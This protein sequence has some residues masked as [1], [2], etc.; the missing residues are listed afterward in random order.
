MS[1]ATILRLSEKR[2]DRT[3]GKKE[4]P[5]DIGELEKSIFLIESDGHIVDRI[6]DSTRRSQFFAVVENS[7]ECVHQ[8]RFAVALAAKRDADGQTSDERGGNHRIFRQSLC[9]VFGNI[10]KLHG[11]LRKGV[12]PG[13]L[14]A[15]GC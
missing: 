2:F 6:D 7:I 11:V 13:D 1:T 5:G 4:A 3:D 15:I 14:P 9:E 12:V 10:C 8:K